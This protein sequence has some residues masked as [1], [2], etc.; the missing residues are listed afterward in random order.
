[1]PEKTTVAN[2][3]FGIK[4]ENQRTSWLLIGGL[5]AVLVAALLYGGD[6]A[7]ADGVESSVSRS[8]ESNGPA[9]A[10]PS[11]VARAGNRPAESLP[12][13]RKIRKWP[14]L[15]PAEVMKHNPFVLSERA[16]EEISLESENPQDTPSEETLQLIAKQKLCD[17]TLDEL[18]RARVSAVF[19][20]SGGNAAVVGER[21]LREGDVFNGVRI[22][23][24]TSKGI[25]VEPMAAP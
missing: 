19:R 20:T 7:G 23:D 18:R 3:V 25:T 1:M 11:P 17:Q 13:A 21:T 2:T 6:E 15:D 22:V 12:V 8:S 16:A 5:G 24:I 14:D 9:D 10:A 4:L